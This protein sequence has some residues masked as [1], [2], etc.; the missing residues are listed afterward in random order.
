MKFS[1]KL[2]LSLCIFTLCFSISGALAQ[3][4]NINSV[5]S[6]T[7]AP[8][9][10]VFVVNN[11]TLS[12]NDLQQLDAWAVG[13]G[14]VILHWDG[15]NW[16]TVSSP[17]N[18]NLYDVFFVNATEGWAVGGSAHHGVILYYNGTW[19]MWNHVSFSGFT[20]HFDTVNGSL[21][22]VTL[23][24]D[25]NAGWIVG[26]AGLTL[27]WNGD[28]WFAIPDVSPN[29]LRSVSLVH[30]STE[31]WAVGDGGTIAHWTGTT[32]NTQT[33]PTTL[34]LYTIQMQSTTSGW[35]A[36]GSGDSGVVLNLNG[37]TW[38]VWDKFLF[39]MNG[40]MESTVN[41]TIHSITT[42]NESSAWACG[43][44]GF[45]M[46][47]SG[48]EWS[49]NS[50]TL[51]NGTLRSVS[52]VHGSNIG[53]LQAWAVGDNGKI[54]IFNGVTWVPEVPFIAV[55]I[56]LSVGLLIVFLGRAKLFRKPMLLK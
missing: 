56:V 49:C 12:N 13:D 2:A 26:A 45:M 31:A 19:N 36:G 40:T 16:A 50:E 43:S 30:D 46:Y 6:P 52:M 15:T 33:S 28:V 27:N 5:N 9:N 7:T 14:G 24:S 42:G 51:I 34:P 10:S 4:T 23:N 44:N 8:L 20:D 18:E 55:P 11:V 53:S 41:S 21:Y 54:L 3:T 25:G 35:A 32:W 47:W 38:N 22:A 17:T 37:S 29:N 39:G 1:F 48:T